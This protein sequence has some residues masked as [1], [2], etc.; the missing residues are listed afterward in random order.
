[1]GCHAMTPDPRQWQ[2][3]GGGSWGPTRLHGVKLW[4][5]H[6]GEQGALQVAPR[7][8]IWT[9]ARP[10]VSSDLDA[11]KASKGTASGFPPEPSS[12]LEE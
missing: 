9:S 12:F 4:P 11:P 1:M 10:G 3:V 6:T 7:R 2:D 8:S 5:P